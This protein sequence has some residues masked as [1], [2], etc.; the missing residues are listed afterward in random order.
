MDRWKV[1]VFVQVCKG[2]YSNVPKSGF[3]LERNMHF[4]V[5]NIVTPL[6]QSKG[7]SFVTLW[8]GRRVDY[9]VSLLAYV[10][11]VCI[12]LMPFPLTLLQSLSDPSPKSFS[13]GKVPF[14]GHQFSALCAVHPVPCS[15]QR[16]HFLDRCSILDMFFCNLQENTSLSPLLHCHFKIMDVQYTFRI[17]HTVLL[18]T[19]SR[20][21]PLPVLRRNLFGYMACLISY[22]N[23]SKW[24]GQTGAV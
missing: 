5:A 19:F 12:Y 17:S 8:G 21:L 13:L 2:L 14:L 6:T 3:I 23:Q 15:V 16:G 4:V 1:V 18:D 22:S 7:V 11:T 20:K 9:F 24:F 10:F